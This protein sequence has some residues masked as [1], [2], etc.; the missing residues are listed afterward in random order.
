MKI[1]YLLLVMAT[2][3]ITQRASAQY[4][5]DAIRFSGTQPGS[6]SR[7][8]ALGNANVSVGGDLT[9]IGGNP[10][11][12]GFFTKSELSITPEFNM[13]KTNSVYL[14]QS[15]NASRNDGN[16]NNASVVFYGK[17]NKA[18]GEDKSKGWLSVNFGANYSRTNNFYQKTYYTGVNPSS[19][20]SDYYADLGNTALANN[21]SLNGYLEGWAE[22]QKLIYLTNGRYEATTTLEGTQSRNI[23]S[24]GGQSDLNF[25]FGANYGNKFYVGAGFGITSIRYNSTSNFVEENYQYIS[26]NQQYVSTYSLDQATRGNGFNGR[27][28]VIYK[29]VEMVRVGATFTT[30]TWYTIDDSSSEGLATKYGTDKTQSD[31][32]NYPLTYRLRTPYKVAG[33]ISVF[34][35]KLGFIT[36]DIEY[37][38]YASTKLSESSDNEFDFSGDN[39]DIKSFYKGAINARFGAEARLTPNFMLRGG[40]GILGSPVRNADSDANTKTISG[41]LG[42]RFANYYIDAT[43]MHV[44]SK[45]GQYP[46]EIGELSPLASIKNTN[47]NIFLT[48]GFRF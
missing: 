41:G 23:V 20:I 21:F 1:K 8:K 22:A 7:I 9:S 14:G 48:V 13:N 47:N 12:L 37:V 31:G 34:A 5:A 27:I 28:G 11:G 35:G 24:T 44:Q 15:S 46:Y 10:A 43:Y 29:P 40:Y 36:G 19:S 4:S 42:Y 32:S 25:S 6:T 38:D 30:P 18:P 17:L 45:Y 2:V 3:A 16:L 26:L 39:A 33:G